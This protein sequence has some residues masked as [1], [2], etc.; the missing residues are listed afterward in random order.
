VSAAHIGQHRTG[1]LSGKSAGSLS[2]YALSTQLNTA[3]PDLPLDIL[4]KHERDTN[5]DFAAK[6]GRQVIDQISD[7]LLIF[8]PRTMHL[9]VSGNK[10]FSHGL[11]R[12][13]C[14]RTQKSREF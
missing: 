2:T 14:S 5:Q 3:V 8:L 4:Q 11:F 9:P 12:E 13:R 1:Y 10:C 6:F 7:K